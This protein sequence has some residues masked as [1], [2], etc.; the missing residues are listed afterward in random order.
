MILSAKSPADIMAFIYH[1]C[2]SKDTKDTH[3]I[4]QGCEGLSYATAMKIR[5]AITNYYDSLFE[6]S[7]SH[8]GYDEQRGQWV[9][10]PSKSIK[11][12]NYMTSLKKRKAQ[13][14]EQAKTMRV[15]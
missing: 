13:T 9:G 11:V 14:S 8:F 3:G 2:E 5:A 7:P 6:D 12:M 4:L 15:I 10:N 1:K